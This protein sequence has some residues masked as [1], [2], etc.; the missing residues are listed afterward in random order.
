MNAPTNTPTN[1]PT[2]KT[3]NRFSAMSPHRNALAVIIRT[4]KAAVTTRCRRE[5]F[6]DFAWQRNYY[7]HI[8]RD[9]DEFNRIRQ[10]IA[11]NP[12]KWEMSRENLAA[13]TGEIGESWQV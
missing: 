3:D 5:G 8:I 9:E 7:E 6:G 2:R 10:Y 1:A 12:L 4:Y 13:R 11:E